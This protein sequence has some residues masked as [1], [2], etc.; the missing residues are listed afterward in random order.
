MMTA[1]AAVAH[2]VRNFRVEV[3]DGI[4]TLLLDEP[5]ESNVVEPG[6]VAEFFRCS[7]RSRATR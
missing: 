1:Q 4:A 3:A 7:T 2:E 6:A 5:G